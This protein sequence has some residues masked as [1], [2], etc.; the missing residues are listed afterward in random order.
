MMKKILIGIAILIVLVIAAAVVVPF[1][2][3][4]DTYKAQLIARV[5]DA[6][7]RDLRIDGPVSFSLLPSLALEAKNVSFSN[8]PG[9]SAKD[10]AKL[11]QLQVKLKLLPLLRRDVEIDQLVLVDPVIA[12]EV[13]KQGKPN[14]QFGAP[15]P[16]AAASPAKPTAAAPTPATAGGGAGF[17]ELRLDDVRLVN[18]MVSYIDQRSGE[19][20]ELSKI[21]MKLSLPGLDSPFTADGSAVWKNEPVTLAV[22]LA[23]PRAFEGGKSSAVTLKLSAKPISFDFKGNAA[24]SA[25]V[26]LDGA[27]DLQVPSVRGLSAWLA[28][29]INMPGT[30]LG[31]LAISGKVSVAGS[32]FDFSDANLSLD[33]IKAKGEFAF[34]SGG[35]RPAMKGKLDVDKLD[36]NPYLPPETPSKPAA[37]GGGGGGGGQSQGGATAQSAGWS[38]A[39]IDFSP[40]KS[41]DADFALS[42]GGL[43]YRKIQVGKSALSL[44]LKDGRL[45]TDLTEL[46]LYQGAGKG[47]V[48]LDGAAAVPAVEMNFNLDKVQIQPLLKD[49]MQMDRLSGVGEVAIAV[50]GHGKS[51]RDIIG[52]LNGKG[53]LNLTNGVIKGMN[54]V[55]MVK[56]VTSAFDSSSASSQ[57]TNFTS[58]SGTYTITNGILR[59]TD[60]ALKSAD[61][62]MTGAGTVDLPKRSVDYKVTPK[63]AGLIAVPVIIKGPWD[64]LSY[65]P[66]LAGMVGDPGK[67]IEGGAKGVGNAVKGAPGAVDSVVKGLLGR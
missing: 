62:P 45:Q 46:A 54:L 10:M 29:P 33:A 35:A 27:V 47:K 9:A 38:D 16:A 40:L 30:G 49:A 39:P 50:T 6:T 51:Q 48:V 25:P 15:A 55:S 8:A 22:S 41:V 19:K 63:V 12:L 61:I 64:S 34:D 20:N 53:D 1:F 13:D 60:L 17:A 37:S 24:G 11:S 7:G 59:N 32:K 28:S 44:H 58:L 42:V 26:K 3:P 66:D 36:V 4:V 65:Q 14:W 56:N 43:Q 5:K 23:N 18:G 2:V 31:P 67:L 57:E 52:A 21:A